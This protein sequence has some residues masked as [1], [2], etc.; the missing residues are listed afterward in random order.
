MS[1]LEDALSFL[2]EATGI[3]AIKR[4]LSSPIVGP[5]ARTTI[6]SKNSL[7]PQ[8]VLGGLVYAG[9]KSGRVF[10][11]SDCCNKKCVSIF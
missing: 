9:S 1:L 7:P 11:T 2:P 6:G 4:G 3:L 5:R 8:K 10:N